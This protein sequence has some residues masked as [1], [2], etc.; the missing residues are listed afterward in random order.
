MGVTA[1][2][3][4]ASDLEIPFRGIRVPRGT[5]T[6]D[7]AQRCAQYAVRL[8]PW[9]FFSHDTALARFGAPLPIGSDPLVLHVAAHRPKREPR[10]QGVVGHRLGE[11]LPAVW[12]V[13][14]I[15]FEHPAR[16]WRHV[17][18]AWQYEDLVAAGDYL[19]GRGG[20]VT[21]DQLAEEVELHATRGR[22]RLIR[23]LSDIR[24]GSESSEET[25]LRLVLQRAGLPEPELNP[26]LRHASGVFIARLDLAYR[27]WRVAVEYDGRQHAF[28]DAQFARDADR[29]HA[30]REAGWEHVRI[31]RHHLRGDGRRAVDMVRSGLLRAGWRP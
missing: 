2:R 22:S 20:L 3:L 10:A 11:R 13:G 5:D 12:H 26:E 31:L 15:P 17:G 6:T 1:G 19:V 27:R 7:A 21:L 23:A 8:M 4:D 28:D 16:A 25:R 18:A 29:W 14:G 24:P 9:Q 30:I